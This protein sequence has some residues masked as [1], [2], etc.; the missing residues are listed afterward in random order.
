MC[1]SLLLE[2]DLEYVRI[3]DPR[4][5]TDLSNRRPM[6]SRFGYIELTAYRETIVS[7]SVCIAT[8]TKGIYKKDNNNKNKKV[9]ISDTENLSSLYKDYQKKKKKIKEV[10][11]AEEKLFKIKI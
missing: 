5:E 11:Q 2:Q 3:F 10:L 8:T 4:W 7:V 9:T 6:A 1:F